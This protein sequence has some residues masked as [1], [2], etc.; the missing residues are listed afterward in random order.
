MTFVHLIMY[1]NILYKSSY[2]TEY[3]DT[4]KLVSYSIIINYQ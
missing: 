3:I 4:M 2:N 1:K